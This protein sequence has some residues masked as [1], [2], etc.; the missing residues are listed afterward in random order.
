[1]HA[2]SGV[3]VC[4]LV[5][6]CSC[7]YRV[8][9]HMWGAGD[10]T[11]HRIFLTFLPYILT[12]TLSLNL[13]LTHMAGLAGWWQNPTHPSV[14]VP[15]ELQTCATT[16]PNIL[17]W[18]Q[19][20]RPMLSRWCCKHCA[21]WALFLGSRNVFVRLKSLLQG[22]AFHSQDNSSFSSCYQQLWML[23]IFPGG[24]KEPKY[25]IVSGKTGDRNEVLA[26]FAFSFVCE[27]LYKCKM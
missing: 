4:V 12:L 25:M 20:S 19:R 9:T 21:G 1:M 24:Q 14:S 15:P 11:R 6:V 22:E 13:E 10:N 5:C 26:V 3:C 27:F 2:C 7:V 17:M 23:D 16:L 8:L 18:V